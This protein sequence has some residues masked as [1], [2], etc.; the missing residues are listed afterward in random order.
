MIRIAT[1]IIAFV[2]ITGVLEAQTI[3]VLHAFTGTAGANPVAGVLRDQKGNLYGSTGWGGA[4]G[5]GTIFKVD[6]NNVST[7]LYSF[8]GGA[9]GGVSTR[10]LLRRAGGIFG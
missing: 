2:F 4:Y 3:T 6:T 7:V 10:L 8:T 9:A 5:W 1:W